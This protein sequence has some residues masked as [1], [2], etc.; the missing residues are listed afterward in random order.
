MLQWVKIAREL[1]TGR[2][3]AE[4]FRA[5]IQSLALPSKSWR[6]EDDQRLLEAVEKHGKGDWGVGSCVLPSSFSCELC[7]CTDLIPLQTNLTS[8]Y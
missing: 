6:A 4:C 1:G 5:Y 2:S 3:P 7:E 8:K